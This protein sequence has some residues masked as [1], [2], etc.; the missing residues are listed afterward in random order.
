MLILR[1]IFEFLKRKVRLFVFSF[2]LTISIFLFISQHLSWYIASSFL[3][4]PIDQR[5]LFG[6]F[7]WKLYLIYEG[8]LFTFL[9]PFL[10]IFF[11]LVFVHIS[12]YV[13]YTP[14]K[15]CT[16]ITESSYILSRLCISP[17]YSKQRINLLVFSIFFIS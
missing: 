15:A 12:C 2:R 16:I 17:F 11:Y 3:T 4:L 1:K 7:N 6:I 5:K 10:L 8:K 14:V 9:C 13:L